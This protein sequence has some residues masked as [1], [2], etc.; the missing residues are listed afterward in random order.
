MPLPIRSRA[1]RRGQGHLRAGLR[2]VDE[3][4]SKPGAPLLPCGTFEAVPVG[5]VV[6]YRIPL[7]PNARR[8]KAGRFG[9]AIRGSR[10]ARLVSYA[11]AVADS[12]YWCKPRFCRNEEPGRS[13]RAVPVRVHLARAEPVPLHF[14]PAGPLFWTSERAGSLSAHFPR[15]GPAGAYGLAAQGLGDRPP[16]ALG[17]VAW[18]VRRSVL[19]YFPWPPKL[20][21]R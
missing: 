14:A 12:I 6:R 17:H 15:N 7:V 9:T 20:G 13:A 4:A 18:A 1:D 2:K 19:V 5:E 11:I 8:F 10:Q 16:P 3:A 21:I